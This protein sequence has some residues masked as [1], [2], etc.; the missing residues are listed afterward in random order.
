M[1]KNVELGDAFAR[2]LVKAAELQL[3]GD[4]HSA[5]Q[6]LKD[7]GLQHEQEDSDGWLRSAVNFHSA[8]IL[9]HAGDL[10]GALHLFLSVYPSPEDRPFY[11]LTAYCTAST[12]VSLG[13]E[14]RAFEELRLRISAA[15][16]Q[17]SRYD[18]EALSL[19]AQLAGRLGEEIGPEHR[20]LILEVVSLWGV[21][22]SRGD[23]DLLDCLET[24][25]RKF[26]EE[27]DATRRR[28]SAADS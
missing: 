28:L 8:S 5:L 10:S 6:I 27:T 3:E 13:D 21:E 11:L 24:A 2:V 19:Y 12:M 7:F 25:E 23:E 14:R 26:R 17:T 20:K 18:L 15:R 4:L 16:G 1:T 9:R 22:G